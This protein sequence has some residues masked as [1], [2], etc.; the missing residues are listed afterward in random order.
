MGGFF[1]FV[2]SQYKI[3][4]DG[5]N[6]FIDLVLHHKR[7]KCLVAIDLKVGKFLPEY[8]G[9]MQFYLTALDEKVR[10]KGENPSTGIILCK[11]KQKTVVEYTLKQSK[12]S[13]AVSGYNVSSNLPES[14]RDEL[15]SPEQI[16]SLIESI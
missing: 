9:K 7:L 11:S 14:L 2:E 4:V 5:E 15:P 12:K 8:V 6:F 3:G 1:A 13:M 16:Q 10:L